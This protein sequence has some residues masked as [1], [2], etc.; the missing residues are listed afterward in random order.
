MKKLI[1]S[2]IFLVG[3]GMSP[4]EMVSDCSTEYISLASNNVGLEGDL[5]LK[6]KCLIKSRE[7][8]LNCYIEKE[9]C[10]KAHEEAINVCGAYKESLKEVK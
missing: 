2:L 6:G 10:E 8:M 1:F 4:K 7:C 9:S 3:C 5:D